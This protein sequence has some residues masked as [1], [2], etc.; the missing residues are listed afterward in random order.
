MVTAGLLGGR[1]LAS[2]DYSSFLPSLTRACSALA[3]VVFGRVIGMR[4]P[5]KLNDAGADLYE[6]DFY[7]LRSRW[8]SLTRWLPST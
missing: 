5:T 2:Q 6:A 8:R 3:S 7:L 4:A 1:R